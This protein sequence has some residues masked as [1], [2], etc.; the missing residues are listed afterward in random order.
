MFVSSLAY[1]GNAQGEREE[2]MCRLLVLQ[3][4]T[5]LWKSEWVI[6]VF[7]ILFFLF[8]INVSLAAG[9]PLKFQRCQER[10]LN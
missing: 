8:W 9:T 1:L 2:D 3:F 5:Y 10:S 4:K 7:C 6:L